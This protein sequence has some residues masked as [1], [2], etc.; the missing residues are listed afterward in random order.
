MRK[1]FEFI[2]FLK[3]RFRLSK[4]GDDCAVLQVEE[5]KELVVTADLL[6]EG[7]DFLI[8]WA[9]ATQI[10]HKALAVSLSD[11]AA[12]GANPR[13]AL[14]SIG[15]S[16]ELWKTDFVEKFYEGWFSL[17]K[18]FSVEL[19]G[20]DISKSEILVIDSVVIGEVEKGKAIRRDGA[21]VNDKIFVTGFLGEAAAGL[22]LLKNRKSEPKRL[23]LRQLEPMP[24]IKTG[25]LICQNSIAS[26]MIDISDGLS[27][28]LWH[29]CKMS[30]VGARIFADA[31]PMSE[32]L[33]R[34]FNFPES[35][36]LALHGGEDFE[37][38]FTVNPENVD[39]LSSLSKETQI[40]LIGEVVASSQIE[41]V[42]KDKIDILAPKGFQHF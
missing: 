20:G 7:V 35:L 11:I 28:D 22:R 4:I 21:K 41:L 36:E 32:E 9:D 3:H 5:E 8:D 6:V 37:L 26:S 2:D 16:Q 38:L 12:M 10:G 30:H 29:I 24:R 13:W 17:A 42:F 27:T 31:I 34:I 19:V 39:K 23:I 15:V 25:R 33:Q 18:D 1:E 40:T 14:V